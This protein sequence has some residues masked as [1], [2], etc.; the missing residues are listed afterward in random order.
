MS[1]CNSVVKVMEAFLLL[2]LLL[3]LLTGY[4]PF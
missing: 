1:G 3:L 4:R 2:L